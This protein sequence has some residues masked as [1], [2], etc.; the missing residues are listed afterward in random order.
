MAVLIS[1][2]LVLLTALHSASGTNDPFQPWIR[3]PSVDF[4]ELLLGGTGYTASSFIYDAFGARQ[5]LFR[6][7]AREDRAT[8]TRIR[9]L[10]LPR[11]DLDSVL[12]HNASAFTRDEP[13][14]L[15]FDVDLERRAPSSQ[16]GIPRTQRIEK[17]CVHCGIEFNLRAA[18]DA[19]HEGFGLRLY[20]LDRRILDVAIAAQ[21]LRR[22]WHATVAATLVFNPPGFLRSDDEEIGTHKFWVQLDGEQSVYEMMHPN[23]YELTEGDVLYL[24]PGVKM[25]RA[26]KHKKLSLHIEFALYDIPTRAEAIAAAINAYRDPELDSALPGA[27]GAF[28]WRHLLLEALRVAWNVTEELQLP[29]PLG[30]RAAALLRDSTGLDPAQTLAHEMARFGIAARRGKLL[31][32]VLEEL[33]STSGELRDWADVLRRKR[34]V[35]RYSLRQVNM[36]FL[37]Y[38]DRMVGEP[39]L[40]K[41]AVRTLHER[42]VR[43]A[44]ARREEIVRSEKDALRRHG[45]EFEEVGKVSAICMRKHV[46]GHTAIN[47]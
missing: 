25:S 22:A 38:L 31:W 7:S 17:H 40:S 26:G 23:D 8:W 44:G 5:H 34:K 20:H 21:H 16:T 42:I 33:S 46:L 14:S 39:G 36:K 28:T 32:P 19:F 35:G 43:D 41:R 24:P 13:L 27:Q 47:K 30:P 18:H 11:E 37:N 1:T 4:L 15:G 12:S 45:Q 29:L 9:R 2:T 10:W 6:D 3:G